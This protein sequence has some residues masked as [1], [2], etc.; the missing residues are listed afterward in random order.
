VELKEIYKQL[1]EAQEELNV[2]YS[3]EKWNEKIPF[4][5]FNLALLDEVGEFTHSVQP[6]WA[7][8]KKTEMDEQN[9]IIEIID[10]LH[11]GLSCVLYLK[12]R[13]IEE[14]LKE[15]INE[16][17]LPVSF[18]LAKFLENATLSNLHNLILA[19]SNFVGVDIERIFK[20]YF[21]KNELN[22]KRVEGGYKEGKYQKIDENGEE[23]NRKLDV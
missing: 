17:T 15:D 18:S 16:E 9:A 13:N 14:I 20:G 22:H 2:K 5:F 11:F 7:W 19:L 12:Q 10:V 23:D 8:W 1:L 4:E 3:G 21:K 6:L